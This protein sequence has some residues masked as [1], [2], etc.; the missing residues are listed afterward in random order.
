LVGD[1]SVAPARS[2]FIQGSKK[3]I[4][5]IGLEEIIIIDT[6]DA[7][8]ICARDQA[9]DVKLIVEKLQEDGSTEYL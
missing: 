1:L 5:T 6:E 7:M 4:A 3:L 9:Q 8:L 2:S